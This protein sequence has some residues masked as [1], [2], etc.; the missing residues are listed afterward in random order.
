MFVENVVFLYP[1]DDDAEDERD[2]HVVK[3]VLP[4]QLLYHPVNGKSRHVRVDMTS[5]LPRKVLS[6]CWLNDKR[7]H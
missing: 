2:G 4:H 7:S 1:K 6:H 5:V 3:G